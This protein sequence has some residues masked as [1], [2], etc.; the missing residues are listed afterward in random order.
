MSPRHQS[1]LGPINRCGGE[2]FFGGAIRLAQK[3]K[4][5]AITKMDQVQRARRCSGRLA[6]AEQC[7]KSAQRLALHRRGF[8]VSLCLSLDE[9]L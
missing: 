3:N 6:L 5:F 9:G 4:S 1:R 2:K 8:H 7:V